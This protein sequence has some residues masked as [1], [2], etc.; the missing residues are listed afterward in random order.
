MSRPTGTYPRKICLWSATY[1]F[2]SA[3]D[4]YVGGRR[5]GKRGR[6]AD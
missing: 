5:S 4:V 6:G 1:L 3:P 2:V